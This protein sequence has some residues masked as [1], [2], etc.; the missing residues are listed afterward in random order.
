MEPW[1]SAFQLRLVLTVYTTN[2]IRS[3][4]YDPGY[5]HFMF[6]LDMS[7]CRSLFG[8]LDFSIVSMLIFHNFFAFFLLRMAVFLSQVKE[9]LALPY[10]PAPVTGTSRAPP[11]PVV[12]P[13]AST[14]AAPLIVLE[15]S[16]SETHVHTLAVPFRSGSWCLRTS[17]GLRT[18]NSGSPLYSSLYITFVQF[19]H[20][21]YLSFVR[22]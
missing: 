17:P 8:V 12:V 4:L 10:V 9:A 20:R 14:S 2:C 16:D 13:V 1:I 21:S 11:I 15:D 19:C 3:A 18:P 6:S 7:T 22:L 5:R